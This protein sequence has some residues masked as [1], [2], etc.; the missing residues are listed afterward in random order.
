[1]SPKNNGQPGSRPAINSSGSGVTIS[2]A[3]VI[4]SLLKDAADAVPPL[5]TVAAVALALLESV[6]VNSHSLSW[7]VVLTKLSIAIQIKSR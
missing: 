5:N 4:L 1:M 7:L 3:I 2:G 6:K